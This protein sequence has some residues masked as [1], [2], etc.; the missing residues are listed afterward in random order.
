[1]AAAECAGANAQPTPSTVAREASTPAVV[2]FI[3]SLAAKDR[4]NLGFVP[5]SGYESAIDRGRCFVLRVNGDSVGFVVWGLRNGILRCHQV[6]VR[7][8]AR[9]ILHGTELLH[10]VCA[11]AQQH[12]PHRIELHCAADLQANLFWQALGF[13]PVELK[14]AKNKRSRQLIRYTRCTPWSK[15]A[16]ESCAPSLSSLVSRWEATWAPSPSTPHAED[17]ALSILSRRRLLLPRLNNVVNALDLLWQSN[18]RLPSATSTDRSGNESSTNSTCGPPARIFSSAS[19]S[20]L[21]SLAGQLSSA[22]R[23]R[24]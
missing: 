10:Q 22:L 24:T 19:A 13:D 20:S 17:D 23:A 21:S 1:M 11:A 15:P 7:D 12:R 6:C 4:K 14:A 9:R 5:L 18:G 8:D 3:E 16:T 2:R